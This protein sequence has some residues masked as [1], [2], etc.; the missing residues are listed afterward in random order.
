MKEILLC[1]NYAYLMFGTTMYVGVLR[2]L[3][4]LWLLVMFYF[5]AKGN[6]P[7]AIRDKRP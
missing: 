5:I 3:T 2:A 7:Q 4:V 6:L 1:I